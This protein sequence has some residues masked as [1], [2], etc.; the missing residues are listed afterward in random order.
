ML[1]G[2]AD[3][4]ASRA[5][6]NPVTG[7]YDIRRVFGPDE[8]KGM[9]DNNTYTNALVRYCLMAAGD[10]ARVLGQR[11]NP[12]WTNVAKNIALPYD[13]ASDRYLARE[14]DD[15][16]KTKQADGELVLYPPR[17]RCPKRRRRTRSTSTPHAPSKTVTATASIHAL[18]AARLG[19]QRKPSSISEIPTARSCAGRSC[20]SRKSAAWTG[21]V[22]DG[23]GRRA[24]KRRLRLR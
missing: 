13:K 8:L 6:K 11:A 14:A 7:K 21:R 19:R 22:R 5:K 23:R 24:A 1:S 10:A 9:V 2:V 15:G 12:K 3:Y 4:F 17:C 16:V 20:C 18:L